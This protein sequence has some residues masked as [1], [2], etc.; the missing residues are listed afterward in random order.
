MAILFY[1]DLHLHPGLCLSNVSLTQEG[2]I[3]TFD[4]HLY[5]ALLTVAFKQS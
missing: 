4:L 2:D 1:D 5:P 3:A